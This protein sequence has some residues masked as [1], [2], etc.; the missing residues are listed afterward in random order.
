MDI[1][2]V[3]IKDDLLAVVLLEVDGKDVVGL[4][5]EAHAVT[6]IEVGH[7]YTTGDQAVLMEA[8]IDH[9]IVTGVPL[10]GAR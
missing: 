4:V 1:K 8:I 6:F 3:V 5:D 10:P 7:R 2:V 9:A